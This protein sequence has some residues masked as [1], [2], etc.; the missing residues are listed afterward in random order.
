MADLTKLLN[1]FDPNGATGKLLLVL[2]AAGMVFAAASNTTA[3]AVDKNTSKED[4]KFLVPAGAVTGVANIGVYYAMTRK[5]INSL[6]KSADNV[7]KNMKESDLAKNAL[8]F[9]N[10]KIAKA[11]KGFLGT[12][13]FKESD[14]YIASMKADYLKDGAPTKYAIDEFSS[15]LKGGAGVLGA[16]AGAVLGCAILTPII[17]DVSAY[18]VQKH[19]EKK[20]PELSQKAYKPYFDPT[21]LKTDKTGQFE[22]APKTPLTLNNY[23]A[24]TNR[25]LKV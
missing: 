25:N 3:A 1:N 6:E 16:F 11:E 24:F 15:S 8:E 5:I 10:K 12:G 17:R 2:N 19:M 7:I 21:H 22:K 20:N 4:K 18:F 23:M 14:K 9:A 13:L